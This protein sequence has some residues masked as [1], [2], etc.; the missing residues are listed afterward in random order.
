MSK[1]NYEDRRPVY[2][3]AIA[4]YGAEMQIVVAIEELSELAKELCKAMRGNVRTGAICEE[5]ADVAIVIEQLQ[6]IFSTGDGV[7]SQMDAKVQRL[8][9]RLQKDFGVQ[10]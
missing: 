7:D 5:I 8:K 2:Q 4:L 6:L 1:M 9:E 10:P 3:N